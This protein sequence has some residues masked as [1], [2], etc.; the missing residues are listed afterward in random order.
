LNHETEHIWQSRY[1]GAFYQE[2]Y[3]G[4]TSFFGIAAGGILLI[5]GDWDY[6]EVR[7]VAY[8]ANP[9][10]Q[11]AYCANDPEDL[12]SGCGGWPAKGSLPGTPPQP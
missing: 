8:E 7:A 11:H 5:N 4:W 12:D 1:F 2:S 6:D 9:W 3:L 10:E